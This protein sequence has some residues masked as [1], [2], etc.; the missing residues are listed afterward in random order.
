MP[1]T[2]NRALVALTLSA[3]APLAQ[4]DITSTFDS[5]AEGW[6]A[7]NGG[8]AVTWNAAWGNP[9]GAIRSGDA[10]SGR[11]WYFA[12][13][14]AY[15]GDLSSYVGGSVTWD[16]LGLT[17]GSAAGQSSDVILEGTAGRIGYAIPGN[18]DLATWQTFSV[19][20]TFSGWYFTPAF[21]STSATGTAVTE[22]EFAA[23]LA[24]ITGFF[25]QGEYRN[26]DDAARL[27]NVLVRVPAPASAGLLLLG[28][29]V[30]RRRRA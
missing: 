16:L 1:N 9:G 21:P 2:F 3:L 5:D 10:T 23:V 27:D 4:A 24:N 19:P 25:I 22:A 12:A 14:T 7:V 13:P 6:T 11:L 30:A 26:G 17:G 28:A 15:H 29:A 8:D 18:I 20:L